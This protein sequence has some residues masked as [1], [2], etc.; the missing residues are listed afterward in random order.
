VDMA[1]ATKI[2]AA[3]KQHRLKSVWIP[4]QLLSVASAIGAGDE[5]IA[6]AIRAHQAHLHPKCRHQPRELRSLAMLSAVR[7][8]SADN[9]IVGLA[10]PTVGNVPLPT[11]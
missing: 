10:V 8:A 5:D 6:V 4:N 1:V 11:R 2:Y 7:S 3:S 9:V